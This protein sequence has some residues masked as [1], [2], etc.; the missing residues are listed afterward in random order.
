MFDLVIA[1]VPCSGSGTWSRTP[2]QLYYFGKEKIQLYAS[3]QRKILEHVTGN[4]KPGGY[5][6]YCTCS[7]FRKE[8]EE[9]VQYLQDAGWT[10]VQQEILTGYNMRADTLFAA[11]LQKPL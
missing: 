1:D 10:V 6:L 4:A 8:N 11:L 9:Q 3:R 5:L 7:V 2:E